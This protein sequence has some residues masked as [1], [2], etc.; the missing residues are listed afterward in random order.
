MKVKDIRK[1]LEGYAEDTDIFV[2]EKSRSNGAG[3]L[4][5]VLNINESTDQDT[6]KILLYLETEGKMDVATFK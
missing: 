5:N 2:L 4:L 6:N 1:I 3:K